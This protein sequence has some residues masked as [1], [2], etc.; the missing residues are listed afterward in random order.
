MHICTLYKEMQI[1]LFDLTITLTPMYPGPVPGY[2]GTRVHIRDFY[3]EICQK[4][5]E[6]MSACA[7]TPSKKWCTRVHPSIS[8]VLLLLL[9]TI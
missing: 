6:L 1:H 7:F 3:N 5:A 2:P 9:Y 4:D 8:G